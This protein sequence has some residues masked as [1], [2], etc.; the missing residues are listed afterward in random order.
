[1]PPSASD[2]TNS[3]VGKVPIDWVPPDERG[4]LVGLDIRAPDPVWSPADSLAELQFLAAT[5]RVIVAGSTLLRVRAPNP[6]TFIG[7]GQA[8]DIAHRVAETN[9]Q[10]V[11]FDDN[12]LPRQ[13]RNLENILKVKV[14]DRTTLILDIFAAHARTA[15]GKLQVERAQIDY[16]LPR[17]SDLWVDFSRTGGGIG[18]RGPGETQLE[19][20]RQE[21]RK[22]ISLLNARI[23]KVR[24]RRS[25]ARAVRRKRGL[26]L[27]GLVGYTNAGKSSLLNALTGATAL[28]QDQ[29]FATLDPLTR[30][31]VLP[32]GR[33]ALLTDT[34]GFIQRLPPRLV[35]AFRATLEEIE[36]ADLLIHVVDASSPTRTEQIDAVVETLE[37]LG[38]ADTPMITVLNKMDRLED[39]GDPFLPDA[40]WASAVDGTGLDAVRA[41]ITT[42]LSAGDVR[43]TVKIPYAEGRLVDLFH[44]EGTVDDTEFTDEATILTGAIPIR[45]ASHFQKYKVSG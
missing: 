12:L 34:V 16:V 28:V 36:T 41:A 15:E 1:L 32:D 40:I 9:C 11:I 45:F 4:F 20:D 19:T 10:T 29:L 26:P 8:E 23:E 2:R 24:A 5:A 31:L 25:Q 21:L 30:A 3:V 42:A 18:T 22:R 14:V 37:D 44:R 33:K 13:Q 38:V 35:A 6:A 27:V 17:L 7:S 39:P 43:L